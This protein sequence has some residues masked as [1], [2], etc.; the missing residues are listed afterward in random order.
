MYIIDKTTRRIRVR[1]LVASL[2]RTRLAAVFNIRP[3]ASHASCDCDCDFVAYQ[4]PLSRTLNNV[5]G[6]CRLKQLGGGGGIQGQGA[7]EGA[8]RLS[9]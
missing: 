3:S 8:V 7:G 6:L 5:Q 1:L 9:D 4:D 2:E